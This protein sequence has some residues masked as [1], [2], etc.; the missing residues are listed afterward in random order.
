VGNA[1]SERYL[2]DNGTAQGSIIS[3]LLFLIMIN[4]LPDTLQDIESSLFADDRCLFKSGR[5]L[6][7]ITKSI[8]NNL[9][10]IST[11][12]DNWGFK[13]S[14]DKT[15]AVVFS[16]RTNT[17]IDLTIN[18][19]AVKIDNKAKFLGLVFDSKLNWNE[20]IKYLEEKCKKR[21]NLMRAVS[22]KHV[23]S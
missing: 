21:L 13:I 16:H 20:H 12:C 2:L 1:L 18:N 3:P 22:G 6:S 11:W 9:E 10:R 7:H 8:Q 4:D 5:N 17:H 14:L 15:V 23:G 19:Q